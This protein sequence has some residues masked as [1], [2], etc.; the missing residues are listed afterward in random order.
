MSQAGQ[1]NYL[2]CLSRNELGAAQL[3]IFEFAKSTISVIYLLNRRYEPFYKWAYR[4]LRELPILS[5]LGDALQAITE[6]DNSPENATLKQAVVADIA[7]LL[8]NEFRA[9]NL[10]DTEGSELEK[11]AYTIQNGIRDAELRNLHIMEGA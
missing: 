11:Q 1:Y 4:G 5:E 7:T 6:L 2:R 9:Q 3:A 10:S 8:S